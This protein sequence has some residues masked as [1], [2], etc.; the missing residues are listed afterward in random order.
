MSDVRWQDSAYIFLNGKQ[1]GKGGYVE[2]TTDEIQVFYSKAVAARRGMLGVGGLLGG[3]LGGLAANKASEKAKANGPSLT[4]PF[5]E[6]DRVE[7]SKKK[8]NGAGVEFFLKNGDS[9]KIAGETMGFGG[10]KKIYPVLEEIVHEKY[11]QVP[12]E[13]LS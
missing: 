9:V 1:T 13:P 12:F 2:A 7:K 6:L 8:S 3:L 5:S 10:L 4:I 11:P